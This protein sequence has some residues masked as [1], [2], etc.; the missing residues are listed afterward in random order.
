MKINRG[1]FVDL[2]QKHAFASNANFRGGG[3]PT[4]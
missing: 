1:R 2:D 3:A 4:E